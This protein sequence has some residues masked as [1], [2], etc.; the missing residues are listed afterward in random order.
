MDTA[1]ADKKKSKK[2]EES[3]EEGE[4]VEDDAEIE[5]ESCDIVD[6]TASDL[7]GNKIIGKR[8]SENSKKLYDSRVK[9]W[10][11]FIRTHHDS[12]FNVEN[13]EVLL[14]KIDAHIMKQFLAHIS[15]KR[16][17]SG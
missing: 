4:D 5:S 15:I 12:C 1:I 2:H 9:T 10:K 7:L 11:D 16:I 17:K 14:D 13:G 6:L 8:L 3:D